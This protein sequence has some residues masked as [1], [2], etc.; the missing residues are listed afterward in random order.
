M[1][2]VFGLGMRLRVLMRTT[3]ENGI[4]QGFSKF[5]ATAHTVNDNVHVLNSGVEF[6][7][8]IKDILVAKMA[9]ARSSCEASRT[10]TYSKDQNCLA[11]RSF[12]PVC[13]K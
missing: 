1:T 8:E 11:E 5:F 2:V 3:L 9:T 4:L 13:E 12:E 10:S 6:K 7:F